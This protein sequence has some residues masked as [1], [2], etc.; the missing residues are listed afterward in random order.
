MLLDGKEFKIGKNDV[1]IVIH[2]SH[3]EDVEGAKIHVD[4]LIHGA[5]PQDQ[6]GV[7]ALSV[8]EQKGGLYTIKGLNLQRGGNWELRMK[9]KKQKLEDSVIFVFPDAIKQNLPKGKYNAEGI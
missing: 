1:G 4:L 8:T 2:G 6:G 7:V 9:I 5:S 3:D